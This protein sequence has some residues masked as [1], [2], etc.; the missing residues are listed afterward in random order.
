MIIFAARFS[1][2]CITYRHWFETQIKNTLTKFVDTVLQD[3]KDS[4]ISVEDY[5]IGEYK[6]QNK[7]VIRTGG[8]KRGQNCNDDEIGSVTAV[9]LN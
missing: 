2:P 5:I 6:V 7:F 9:Y 8:Y 1:T 3:V 4:I